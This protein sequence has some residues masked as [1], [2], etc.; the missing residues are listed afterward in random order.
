MISDYL[1][2]SAAAEYLGV[3]A[4]YLAKLRCLSSDGPTY[5]K[6]GRSVIY[7]RTDLDKWVASRRRVSTS[8]MEN[9]LA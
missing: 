8:T 1:R 9:E 4:Q 7:A 5:S 3:S 2:P 6:I